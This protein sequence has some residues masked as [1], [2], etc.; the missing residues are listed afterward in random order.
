MK[1]KRP[2]PDPRK[3]PKITDDEM[4]RLYQSGLALREVGEIAGISRQAVQTRLKK[5]V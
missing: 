3:R 5:K 2:K 1:V 4:G